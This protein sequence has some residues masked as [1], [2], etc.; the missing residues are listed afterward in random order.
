MRFNANNNVLFAMPTTKKPKR[1]Y[2]RKR[3]SDLMDIARFTDDNVSDLA[4]KFGYPNPSN[5]SE[6]KQSLE[7]AAA[8]YWLNKDIEQNA[9]RRAHIAA[10]VDEI[11]QLTVKLRTCLSGL[12]EDTAH[13]FAAL[14]SKVGYEI[15][16]SALSDQVHATKTRFGHTI[17]RGQKSDRPNVITRLYFEDIEEGLEIL[18]GY[19]E[20]LR[21]SLL[22]DKTG[23]REKYALRLWVDSMSRIWTDLF[24]KPFTLNFNER[25]MLSEAAQFCKE[26]LKILDPSAPPTSLIR[27]MRLRTSKSPLSDN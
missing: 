24:G 3:F 26:A 17:V 2:R 10:A 25:E 5:L 15:T 13:L 20:E 22:P 18:Q 27:P 7:T 9:P 23:P 8:V 11:E 6:L 4:N 19:C 12:D 1:G 16:M 21:T 14:E